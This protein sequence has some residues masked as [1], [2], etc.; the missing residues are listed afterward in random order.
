MYNT[1]SVANMFIADGTEPFVRESDSHLAG[2]LWLVL[3]NEYQ[4]YNYYYILLYRVQYSLFTVRISD[5]R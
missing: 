2:F 4:V 1:S 3:S 5:I